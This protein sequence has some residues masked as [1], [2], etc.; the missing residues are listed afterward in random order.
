MI[1]VEKLIELKGAK[2]FGNCN[3]CGKTSSED[4][5]LMRI[6]FSVYGNDSTSFCLCERCAN[7][8]VEELSDR[9]EG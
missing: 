1:T 9:L 4:S 7:T 6:T 8:L 2:K 5:T 3:S